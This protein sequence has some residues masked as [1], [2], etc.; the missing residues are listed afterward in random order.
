MAGPTLQADFVVVGLGPTG[1]MATAY[2]AA[3]GYEVIAIERHAQPYALPRA[4][5]VDHEIV[6]YLQ[7]L[8]VEEAFLADAFPVETYAWYNGKGDVLLPPQTSPGL[9]A[10]GYRSD[11]MM[12]QPVLEDALLAAVKKAVTPPTLLR[13]HD[14]VR[15]EQDAGGVTCTARRCLPG[16]VGLP[17][18]DPPVEIRARYL[19][20]C[21]GS[22]STVRETQGIPRR[23]FGFNESWLDV[24]V[25][26]KRPLE[27]RQPHQICDPARPVY[28]GPLGNRHHRWEWSLLPGEDPA[29]FGQPERAWSLLAEQSITPDDVEIVRQLVYTF[30]AKVAERWRDGAVFLLGDAAHTMPPFMGQ[31]ACSGLRD[32]NNLAWKLDLVL[33]GLAGEDL[34][35][36]YQRER[37]PHTNRWIELSIH[38]GR[39]SCT[40]D[41]E[42]A[43]TRDLALLSGHAPPLPEP[44]FLT[45]G[46]L[47]LPANGAGTA[48]VGRLFPQRPVVRDG[49]ELRFDDLAG[50]SFILVTLDVAAAELPAEALAPLCRIGGRSLRLTSGGM[51]GAVWDLGGFYSDWFAEAGVRA[52]VVRPDHYVFGVA[53]SWPE[54]PALLQRLEATVT[55][56]LSVR[57]VG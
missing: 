55:A 4:G 7:E 31:G 48:L 46:V 23:D 24:D 37:E 30:E 39:I 40:L 3:L 35:D 8:G 11:Y 49:R 36:S 2:L 41:V 44:P 9:A 51:P 47:D 42:E 19:L 53:K 13:G 56:G 33:Q 12:Y 50:S 29:E 5:H 16:T 18:L 26:L 14:F 15:L 38:L 6:R 43:A 20:A 32:A 21:D 28:I 22:R 34:L 25:R 1:L 10:S 45:D 52:V 17:A 57:S 54:I 27:N